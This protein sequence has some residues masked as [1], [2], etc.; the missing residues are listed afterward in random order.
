MQNIFKLTVYILLQQ[1]NY[2]YRW[3]HNV[4]VTKSIHNKAYV[5]KFTVE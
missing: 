1:I 3:I 4:F 5:T 2:C